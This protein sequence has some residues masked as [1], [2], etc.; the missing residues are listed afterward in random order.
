MGL[1]LICPERLR[2]LRF[3][4]DAINEH[5]EVVLGLC[6]VARTGCPEIFEAFMGAASVS[7][8]RVKRAFQAYT[9]H[10]VSHGCGPVQYASAVRLPC[11]GRDGAL[12][13]TQ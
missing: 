13:A 9:D 5:S 4:K 11:A 7:S 1:D 8:R 3:A 2:L 6:D 12:F 10:L